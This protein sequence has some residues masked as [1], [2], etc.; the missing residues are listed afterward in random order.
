MGSPTRRALVHFSQ[1]LVHVGAAIP[2]LS[3]DLAEGGAAAFEP[4]VFE[5][6]DSEPQIARRFTSGQ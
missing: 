5:S 3:A 1:P 6:G 4:P 2:D